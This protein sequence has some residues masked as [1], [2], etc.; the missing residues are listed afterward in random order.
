MP[1]DISIYDDPEYRRLEDLIWELVNNGSEVDLD[2]LIPPNRPDFRVPLERVIRRGDLHWTPCDQPIGTPILYPGMKL[3]GL[4]TLLRHLGAGG[5]GTVFL[6]QDPI[7]PRH[8]AVKIL[9]PEIAHEPLLFRK[10]VEEMLALS[11]L[12]HNNIVKVSD[13]GMDDRGHAFL[14]MEYIPGPTLADILNE[15]KRAPHGGKASHIVTAILQ[16]Q[17]LQSSEWSTACPVDLDAPYV[18]WLIGVLYKVAL[19]LAV[20][21]ANGLIHFDLKPSNIVFDGNGEPMLVD[22]GLAIAVSALRQQTTSKGFFGTPGYASPE[23]L[24]GT[25][26]QCSF[27]SDIFSFGVV[28]YECLSLRRPFEGLSDPELAKTVIEKPPIPLRQANP[29]IQWELEALTHKCLEKQPSRR[30]CN[31]A[32]L[33]KDVKNLIGARENTGQV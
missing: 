25:Q 30:Y 23:Q 8:C 3:G 22:F 16:G 24:S 9:K 13:A 26:D 7:L 5:M 14:V 2:S 33:A 4:Y 15:L 31:G 32:H 20:V 21:H 6:A 1:D 18:E 28:L 10:F 27:E 19:A 11:H 29:R 12:N 17:K